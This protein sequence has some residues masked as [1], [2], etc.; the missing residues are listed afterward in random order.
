MTR[1]GIGQGAGRDGSS[2]QFKHQKSR[3]K[4]RVIQDPTIWLGAWDGEPCC[5]LPLE[6]CDCMSTCRA[7]GGALG[8]GWAAMPAPLSEGARSR[9]GSERARMTASLSSRT[10]GSCSTPGSGAELVLSS[11]LCKHTCRFRTLSGPRNHPIGQT[12]SL[13][14]IGK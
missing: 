7:P 3:S 5:A 11:L 1:K 2:V 12:M 14:A 6:P 10:V 13:G 8:M 9:S 4:A